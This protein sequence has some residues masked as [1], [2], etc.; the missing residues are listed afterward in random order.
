MSRAV[1]ASLTLALALLA[2]RIPNEDHC[3]RRQGDATCMALDPS[4]PHCSLCEAE[5][6]GCVESLALISAQCRPAGSEDIAATT[7]ESGTAE[8][9]T[10]TTEPET[11]TESDTET[12]TDQTESETDTDETDTDETESD[13]E[14]DPVCGNGIRESGE[15][16]DGEDF[17]GLTCANPYQLPE[18]NLVCVPGECVISTS[19]CC[20]ANGQ[21]C[22][23]GDCCNNNC[24]LLTN[25]C[26]L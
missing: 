3:G 21:L 19:A 26:G 9:E 2:C 6:D 10:D 11:D 7:T 20:L 1:I 13:T 14:P 5:Y 12:D 22:T 18:G 4:R 24:N 17:G 15:A 25:K 23:P 8:P 16:C